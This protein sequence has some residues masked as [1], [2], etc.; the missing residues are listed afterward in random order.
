MGYNIVGAQGGCVSIEQILLKIFSCDTER[1]CISGGERAN[2][3]R[4]EPNA[5]RQQ[6]KHKTASQP[7]TQN[8]VSYPKPRDN[9]RDRV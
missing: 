9:G 3:W 4:S 6:S 8:T 7:K 5:K 1:F 2:L